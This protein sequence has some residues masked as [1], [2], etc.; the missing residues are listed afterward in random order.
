MSSVRVWVLDWYDI[1][2]ILVA[3]SNGMFIV[4]LLYGDQIL[5]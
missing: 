2:A 5:F 1:D 4:G 3:H